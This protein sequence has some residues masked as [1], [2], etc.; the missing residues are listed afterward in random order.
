LFVALGQR[1]PASEEA[2]EI[3]KTTGPGSAKPIW[4]SLSGFSGE[5][6]Q[7][8]QFDLYVQGFAFTNSEAAQY[9]ISGSNNGNLQAQVT[10]SVNKNVVLSK[11][12]S[13]APL[14]R[15]VHRFVDDFVQTRGY[16]PIAETKIACKVERGLNSEIFCRGLR[17][18]QRAAGHQRQQHRLRSLLGSRSP[19]PILW[20]LQTPA[21]RH[22][23]PGPFHR[24]ATGFCPVWRFEHEPRSLS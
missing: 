20:L 4:V 15:Q 6:L 23:L 2:I 12:Y 18:S 24:S 7:V 8:L 19:R 22:F 11:A 21:R 10:D 17:W 14:R 5:A 3:S 1:I 13:G 9:L 16:K